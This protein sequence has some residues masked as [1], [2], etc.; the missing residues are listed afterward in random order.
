[1]LKQLNLVCVCWVALAGNAIADSLSN[2][3]NAYAVGNYS[4][5]ERLFRPLAEQGN[6]SAQHAIGK[7]YYLGQGVHQ[8]YAEA[9]K[10][11]RLAADQGNPL[12]QHNLGLIYYLGQGVP[13]DYKEAARWFQLAAEQGN[14]SAQVNIGRMYYLGQGVSQDYKEAARWFRLGAEQGYSKGQVELGVLYML[15]QGVP[16]DNVRAYMWV[17]LAIANDSEIQKQFSEIRVAVLRDEIANRMN[18]NQIAEARELARRC[19][20]NRFR[21]C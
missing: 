5:A 9:M 6:A 21:G 20:E 1:M 8:D 11:S 15:G 14:A 19:T 4:I 7:M 18:A 17:N 13:Q 3:Q 12:A 16:Q 2:A 10:W